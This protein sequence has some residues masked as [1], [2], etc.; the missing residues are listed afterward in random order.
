[1]NRYK[2]MHYNKFNIDV[3]FFTISILYTMVNYHPL[4]KD[5]KRKI[6]KELQHD[7]VKYAYNVMMFG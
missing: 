1:M 4:L 7:E 5:F 3:K 2:K 6:E